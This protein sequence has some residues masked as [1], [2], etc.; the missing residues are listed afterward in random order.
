MLTYCRYKYARLA[1][2]VE[3]L[4]DVEKATGSNPVSR[5]TTKFTENILTE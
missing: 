4:I 2:L 1:H 5:T 3:R